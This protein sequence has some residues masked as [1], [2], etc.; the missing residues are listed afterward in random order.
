[1][2]SGTSLHCRSCGMRC[3]LLVLVVLGLPLQ[4]QVDSLRQVL[5]GLPDD[6]SR[7]PVLKELVRNLVFV[8]PDSALPYAEDYY[9]LA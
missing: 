2:K 3:A 4:A 8:Q 7:L 1:M 5:G 6:T 9:R